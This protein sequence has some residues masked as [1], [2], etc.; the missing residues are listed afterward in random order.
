VSWRS[1]ERRG[2]DPKEVDTGGFVVE[3]RFTLA[4]SPEQVWEGLT[5]DVSE[6]WDHTV[7][8]VPFRL[9][10]EA[11]PGGGLYEIFDESG[12]GVQ[13]AQ[14]IWAQRNRMLKLRGPLGFSGKTLDMV[15]TF[16]LED[17][18]GGTQLHL[19]VHASGEMEDGWSDAVDQVWDHFIGVRLRA[20]L[21][22]DLPEK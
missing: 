16:T 5:G 15:H 9:Y 2:A 6:W 20:W 21:A 12:E 10:I 13:H 18:G 4:A 3:K 8:G 11:K 22:G 1:W 14:V 7:S 19:L 17:I